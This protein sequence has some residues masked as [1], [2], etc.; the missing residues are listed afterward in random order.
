MPWPI[1]GGTDAVFY[2][3]VPTFPGEGRGY[4]SSIG[5]AAGT[6]GGA[7]CRFHMYRVPYMYYVHEQKQ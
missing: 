5:A 1:A 6:G 2:T 4:R 7:G 3:P